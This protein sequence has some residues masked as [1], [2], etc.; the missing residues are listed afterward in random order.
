MLP[1]RP[2]WLPG[3]EELRRFYGNA[4][5]YPFYRLRLTEYVGRLLPDG[6]CALLDVG[7]GDGSL[8]LAFQTF[9][10]QTTMVGLE[11][12]VRTATRPGARI[13]P[14][15][16]RAI[17]FTDGSFDVALLS[18]VLHHASDADALMREV[19]RVTRKRIIVKDH[20]SSGRIDDL[21]LA[22]LDVMGNLRLGAQVGAIYLSQERWAELFGSLPSVR[23]S[24]FRNLPFRRGLLEL[25]FSNDLEVIFALDV[26][27]GTRMAKA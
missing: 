18:N 8:G 17:P 14:F 16:G 22:A 1:D 21:K 6:P 13:L 19:R 24:T 2:S 11:V 27:G 26:K 5:L 23:V 15:D 4:A 7:A 20:L 12:A 3:D 25:F 9:R 10:P